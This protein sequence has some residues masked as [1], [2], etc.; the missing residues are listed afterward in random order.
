MKKAASFVVDLNRENFDTVVKDPA[1][2]VLVEFYAP[3]RSPHMHTHTHTQT[4]AQQLLPI[5]KMSL[6]LSAPGCGHCKALT[7]TYDEVA[8]TF[9]NDENV[10]NSNTVFTTNVSLV[11]KYLWEPVGVLLRKA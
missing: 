1:K 7:P 2:N 10:S 5:W 4:C 6:I 8:A 11:L 9:K 3:C